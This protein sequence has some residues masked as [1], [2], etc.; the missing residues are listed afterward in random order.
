LFAGVRSEADDGQR[1]VVD[2]VPA[3][4][5]EPAAQPVTESAVVLDLCRVPVLADGGERHEHLQANEP[6]RPLCAHEIR[7]DILGAGHVVGLDPKRAGEGLS[8]AG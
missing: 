2:D 3:V 7:V 5:A 6:P 1:R 8:V 4:V